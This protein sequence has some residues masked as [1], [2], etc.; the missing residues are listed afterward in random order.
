MFAHVEGYS[1][2]AGDLSLLLADM[3]SVSALGSPRNHFL[4]S[5]FLCTKIL[6]L[7]SLVTFTKLSK[8]TL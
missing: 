1:Q 2:A 3:S 8:C 4:H 6:G 5:L 7:S